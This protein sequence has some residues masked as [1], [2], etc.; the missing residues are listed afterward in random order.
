LKVDTTED[1]PAHDQSDWADACL[2]MADGSRKWLDEGRS[3]LILGKS[4]APFAFV[5]GGKPSSECIK[6]FK[7][8][9]RKEAVEAGVKYEA[10]WEDA[11]TGLIVTATALVFKDYPAIDWVL[12]LENRGSGDTPIIE[13]ISTADL[14]VNTGNDKTPVDLHRLQGDSRS[15]ASFTPP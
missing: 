8:T 2:V 5:Y 6:E 9:A 15:E 11:K 7:H 13:D 4:A 12:H 10:A 14:D 1:G 3:R